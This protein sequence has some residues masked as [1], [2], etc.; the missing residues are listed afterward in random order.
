MFLAGAWLGLV[1]LWSLGPVVLWW[2]WSSGPQTPRCFQIIHTTAAS[3]HRHFCRKGKFHG[4]FCLQMSG[5]RPPPVTPALLK[6]SM[7]A[8]QRCHHH[9]L[10]EG[11]LRRSFCLQM[12]GLRPP[13]PPLVFKPPIYAMAMKYQAITGSQMF[14]IR[15]GFAAY[16]VRA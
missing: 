14:A 10:S 11:K 4:S 6:P 2:S 1:W 16:F 13:N 5:L 3:C 12:R 15:E 8:I 7:L 9:V